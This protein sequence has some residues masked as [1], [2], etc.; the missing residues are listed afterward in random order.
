VPFANYCPDY[1]QLIALGIEFG[2]RLSLLTRENAYAIQLKMKKKNIL[3]LH[4]DLYS[5]ATRFHFFVHL[6][7]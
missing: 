7:G 3:L 5:L 1:W 6:F 2:Y 4:I